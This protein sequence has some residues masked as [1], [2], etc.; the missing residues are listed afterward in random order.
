MNN[1]TLYKRNA[2]GNIVVWR[3]SELPNGDLS[4]S[5]GVWGHKNICEIVTPVKKKVNEFISRVNAKRKEGYKTVGDLWDN[6]PDK[7]VYGSDFDIDKQNLYNYLQTYLPKYNTTSEGFVLPMLAK[8]LEDNKP[9]EKF[10]DLLGQW[11]I[12]GLRCLV[13]AEVV[14]GDLFSNIKL[15]YTSREG[16]KWNLP[17]MDDILLPKLSKNLIDLMIDEDAYLDGELYLP[18]YSVND[19]NS[20]VKNNTLP[21]HY[22]LQYW[23]YDIAVENMSAYRRHEYIDKFIN[24]PNIKVYDKSVHMNN[25]EQIIVLPQYFIPDIINAVSKRDSFIDLGFEGLILR[26]PDAEYA[27]GKRN[28]SMFKYKRKEDG[29]FKIVDIKEDKRGLPIYTLKND[30]NDELFECTINLPQDSQRHQLQ[31]KDSLIG[32]LG[33]VEYRERSGIKQVPFH[34]KLIKIYV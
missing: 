23:C 13:G 6:A 11:K 28:S 14:S 2:K 26:N 8:T 32:K 20:F 1:E 9:F 16:T 25:K 24:H 29:M 34:A 19:I 18:G 7:N 3:I 5:H 10:G 12:N 22:K 31:I 30:I 4:I 15:T 33:L 27:F 21:Q 17:W